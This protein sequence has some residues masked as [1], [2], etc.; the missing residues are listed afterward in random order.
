MSEFAE[1]TYE[2]LMQSALE[3]VSDIYDKREGSMIYNGNAPCLAELAQLYI[4]MDFVFAATYIRTAPREYL[5]KRASDRSIFPKEATNAVF[6]GE[7][8]IEV[9]EGTR[10]SVEDL[11]F[12]VIQKLDENSI[13]E[14][15]T[16]Q[17]YSYRVQCETPGSISNDYSGR[18]ISIDYVAG[19]SRAELCELIVPGEDDEDTEIFR[20]R[21][22]EAMRSIAFGGNQAD[23]KQKVLDNFDGIKAVKVHPVWNEDIKPS[24][25]IPSESVVAWYESFVETVTNTE[26][27]QWLTAVYNAAL[28]KKLTVGGSVKLTLLSTENETP[29]DILLND[30]QQTID[31]TTNA[32]EG[33]GYAPIGHVVNVVGV[34][35][36]A[37]NLK[38]ALTLKGDCKSED[39]KEAIREVVADYFD[40][41]IE[42]WADLKFLTVRKA[43]IESRILT[44]CSDY[45]VDISETFIN[46][47]TDNI[48]LDTDSIPMVGEVI[49]TEG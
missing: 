46:G 25:L 20:Q 33:K 49:V 21:V 8:N 27:K 14:T 12:V 16:P 18:M 39:A 38:L 34:N 42:Q 29:S 41:L 9:P 40:E 11:N 2:N 32:G 4:A 36:Q 10:F 23:Y 17:S 31:P 19:L 13:P 1:K 24:T 45:V 7:F 44:K 37:I 26:A 35:Q 5:I 43:H 6:R 48:V 28:L 47:G 3:K 15:A 30:V 22:L